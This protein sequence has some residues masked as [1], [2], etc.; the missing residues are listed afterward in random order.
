VKLPSLAAFT[1]RLPRGNVLWVILCVLLGLG[2]ISSVLDLMHEPV[3]EQARAA[4][5]AQQLVFDAKTATL[6]VGG[7]PSA[8]AAK[9]KD[10]PPTPDT[11]FDVADEDDA[12]ASAKDTPPAAE[13]PAN[14]D[15][16]TESA[17]TA[18]PSGEPAETAG[19]GEALNTTPAAA[20]R[21]VARTDESLVPAP[22]PEIS[23]KSEFGPVPKISGDNSAAKLYA[24][25]YHAKEGTMSLA[26]VVTGLGFSQEALAIA[27][28]LPKDISLSFSPY[29]PTLDKHIEVMRDG[30]HEAWVDIPTQTP[31]YPA[32]DPGPLGLIASLPERDMQ[33][34]LLR[35]LAV[36][37]GVVGGIFA[38]NETLSEF[39][40]AIKP[41][42]TAFADRGLMVLFTE[43]ERASSLPPIPQKLRARVVDAWLASSP[44]RALVNSKLAGLLAATQQDGTYI[45]ALEGTPQMLRL[46]KAWSEKLPPVSPVKLV[47]LSALY[48][49]HAEVKPPPKKEEAPK[50]H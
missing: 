15:A 50:G 49:K 13:T 16:A 25:R 14:A 17:A 1:A 3:R 46:L 21:P 6:I 41:I 2:A 37:P 28:S 31:D 5:V 12:T 48:A 44:S 33:T 38:P 11:S 9:A 4:A 22:A 20:L 43:P 45:M 32:T 40:S 19:Q 10:T 39:P 7:K 34:R 26:I 36:S 30:G 29:A 23:E 8:E 27:L 42:L 47:P 24:R 35:L 18:E